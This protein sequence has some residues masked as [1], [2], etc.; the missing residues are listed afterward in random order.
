MFT[1]HVLSWLTRACLHPHF[2]LILPVPSPNTISF[3]ALSCFHIRH[4]YPL[5][6]LSPAMY[7]CTMFIVCF[8]CVHV[9]FLSDSLLHRNLLPFHSTFHI[10]L[11]P[12]SH[13]TTQHNVYLIYD[14]IISAHHLWLLPMFHVL[15]YARDFLPRTCFFPFS[16][17]PPHAFFTSDS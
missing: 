12:H 10:F 5:P 2:P 4:D 6:L 11:T 3:L 15:R 8:R 7:M 14:I 16:Y 1:L 9:P 17:S 13:L